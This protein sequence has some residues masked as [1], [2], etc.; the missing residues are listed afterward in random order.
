MTDNN[1]LYIPSISA[2]SIYNMSVRGLENVMRYEYKGMI[3][4][5]LELIKLRSYKR[6][7]SEK[8]IEKNN[9]VKK[10][11][12]SII[13]ISFMDK[14]KNG[15]KIPSSVRDYDSVMTRLLNQYKNLRRE[16]RKNEEII[17]QIKNARKREKLQKSVKY[18]NNKAELVKDHFK[19]IKENKDTDIFNKMAAPDL[20]KYLYTN[21]F[22]FKGR[23]YRFYKR[24][25]SKSRQSNA[26]FILDEL[27]EPMIEWSN[28]GLDLTGKLDVASLLAYQSLVS[29]SIETTIDINPKNIF[30]TDDKFSIFEEGAIEV[31]NDLK[32]VY[33]ENATIENNIWDGEGLIEK[34][35][36]DNIGRGDKGM[37]LT[38]QHFWKSC[39]FS[40][41][42]QLFLIDKHKELTD[43]NNANY[44]PKVNS[45]YQKWKLTDTFRNKILAKDILVISTPSSTKF[46]KYADGK[47]KEA[48]ANWCKRV[49]KDKFKFGVC[50]SEK[51]SKN[52]DRSYSSYQMINTLDVDESGVKDLAEF[53]VEHIK[54]LQGIVDENGNVDDEPFIEY[55]ENNKDMSN[56]Y[57]MLSEIY[58]I[59]PDIV[60]TKMFRNYRA[61]QISNYKTKVKGGRLLLQGDYCTVCSNPYELLL[62]VV[63]QFDN[64]SHTLQ[65]NQVYTT[66]YE[67]NEK[68]IVARNPHNSMNNYFE[69]ENVYNE[70]LERYFN[71]KETPNIIVINSIRNNILSRLNGMDMDSDTLLVLKDTYMQSAVNHTLSNRIYPVILNK[72]KSEPNPTEFNYSNI[73]EIDLKTEKSQSWIGETTNVAQYQVSLFWDVKMNEDDGDSKDEKLEQIQKNI[74]VAVVLSNVAIDYSKKIVTVDVN[75]ALRE[76]R[77]CYTAK[78]LQP[79]LNKEGEEARYKRSGEVKMKL[80]RRN[81][82]EFWK[83]VSNSNV[84]K[85]E[86]YCPMDLLIKYIDEIGKAP[87]RKN[88][89]FENLLIDLDNEKADEQQINDIINLVKDFDEKIKRIN[90]NEECDKKDEELYQEK[91]IKLEE[92]YDNLD[93]KLAKKTIRRA[94]IHKLLKLISIETNK[95][96]STNQLSSI[97]IHL[98]N[99]LYR[100]HG[101]TFLNLIKKK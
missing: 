27:Y 60:R 58:K 26:L 34:S 46:L 18:L 101:K 41:N 78:S 8:T 95:K 62:S 56:A 17:K 63:D 70:L 33:N 30:I 91:R 31:G 35:L 54:S 98:L 28:M 66:L 25:A 16:A 75:K 12:D 9:K 97:S 90:S 24:T 48:Y 99:S 44:D 21:G 42:I 83:Y 68:Y 51:P 37:I 49:K 3:P 92:A 2:E 86:F 84:N 6:L 15:E 32:A 13:N 100:T 79:V 57:E 85:E 38:R 29:S 45:D 64:E 50:K 7:L 61:K 52:D 94:T 47:E 40:S 1:N 65:D 55:L 71:F 87:Y 67:F 43:P 22:T 53:E 93:E 4:Y 23:K 10:Y 88:L 89:A 20:R 77:S 19:R 69:V 39:L 96:T 72:I 73:A 82:P 14:K 80:K 59:N 76:I 74:A 81:K 5:S 11:S 36:L